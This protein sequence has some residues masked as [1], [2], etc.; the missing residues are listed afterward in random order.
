[1]FIAGLG[2]KQIDAYKNVFGDLNLLQANQVNSRPKLPGSGGKIRTTGPMIVDQFSLPIT[3]RILI[4]ISPFSN[5]KT[6][7]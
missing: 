3:S 1:M 7:I 6:N 5:E 2:I 4:V